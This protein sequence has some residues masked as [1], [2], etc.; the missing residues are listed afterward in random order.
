MRSTTFKSIAIIALVIISSL[1]SCKKAEKG[2]KGDTGAAG[3]PGNAN[4]KSKIFDNHAWIYTAPQY[5]ST[6]YFTDINQNVIDYGCVTVAME[7][8]SNT[9]VPLPITIIYSNYTAIVDYEY[10]LGGIRI[11]VANTLLQQPSLPPS[12]LK[13]KVTAIAGTPM[14]KPFPVRY[15]SSEIQQIE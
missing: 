1:T 8:G 10:F 5:V 9:W 6:C 11:N 2:P 13:F 15:L 4:V 14:V 3:S 12:N 7:N